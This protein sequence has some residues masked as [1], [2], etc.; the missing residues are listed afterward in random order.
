MHYTLTY[1]ERDYNLGHAIFYEDKIKAMSA[2]LSA[3]FYGH[4]N[5]TLSGYRDDIH[6][7][8]IKPVVPTK[9]LPF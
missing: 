2:Y 4:R 3:V 1:S 6:W 8:T 7:T 5:V 9:D